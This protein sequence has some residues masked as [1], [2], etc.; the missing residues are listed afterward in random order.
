MSMHLTYESCRASLINP[1]VHNTPGLADLLDIPV[2]WFPY[3][4]AMH[5][6]HS[7]YFTSQVLGSFQ[8]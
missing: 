7:L 4:L 1:V 2:Q 5:G 3:D 8:E 6:S